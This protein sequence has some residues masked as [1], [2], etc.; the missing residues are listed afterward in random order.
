MCVCVLVFCTCLPYHTISG[1]S[2]FRFALLLRILANCLLADAARNGKFC[3]RLICQSMY[4]S[5]L[6]FD[7]DADMPFSSSA[8]IVV[9]KL[10]L[11]NI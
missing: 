6:V 8:A 7:D 1:I 11:A 5:D 3:E 9:N 10:N 2:L 4:L